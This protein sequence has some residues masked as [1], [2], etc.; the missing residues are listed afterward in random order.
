ME[1]ERLR[2]AKEREIAAKGFFKKQK[3]YALN[4]F[5]F[6]CLELEE[7]L[8]KLENERKAEEKRREPTIESA[9]V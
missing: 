9:E 3:K 4:S 5:F 8:I 7:L 1:E 2:M 6:F